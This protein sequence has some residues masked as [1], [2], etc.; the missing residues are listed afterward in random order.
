MEYSATNE[1]G[2]D[3]M[4]KII[5]GITVRQHD[6]ILVN[7]DYY[8]R[9]TTNVERNIF[10]RY[11]IN[12][13]CPFC[14]LYN[15]T[16]LG[17][18]RDEQHFEQKVDAYIPVSILNHIKAIHSEHVISIKYDCRLPQNEAYKC[19]GIRKIVL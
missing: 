18:C 5:E 14:K 15:R 1:I 13:F 7:E 3:E 6:I 4:P 17:N 8:I 12:T 2:N 11:V 10:T 16:E 9:Y 19:C